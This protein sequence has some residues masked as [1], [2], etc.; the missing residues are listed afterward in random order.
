MRKVDKKA[1]LEFAD[2]EVYWYGRGNR[3]SVD[4]YDVLQTILAK[5]TPYDEARARELFGFTDKDFREALLKSP[6][7]CLHT[8]KGGTE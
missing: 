3:D 8:G 6:P 1:F 2:K 7:A 4:V 5:K